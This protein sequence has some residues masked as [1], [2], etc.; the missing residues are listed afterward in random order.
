M[1][2]TIL[3]LIISLTSL[4]IMA[5]SDDERQWDSFVDYLS[6]NGARISVSR[7]NDVKRIATR[8]NIVFENKD[9]LRKGEVLN[10][11]NRVPRLVDSIRVFLDGKARNSIESYRYEN[12]SD[13]TDTIT[14]SLALKG[15]GKNNEYLLDLGKAYNDNFLWSGDY[16]MLEQTHLATYPSRHQLQEI[17][18]LLSLKE[19]NRK[20]WFRTMKTCL[21]DYVNGNGNLLILSTEENTAKSPY[22]NFHME[23]FDS[24]LAKETKTAKAYPI[25]YKYDNPK[26][27]AS[28]H[29]PVNIIKNIKNDTDNTT[30]YHS[31][32]FNRDDIG[33]SESTG[34]LY[35]ISKENAKECYR[36]LLEKAKDYVNNHPEECCEI[37]MSN[38]HFSFS[39]LRSTTKYRINHIALSDYVLAEMGKDGTLYI[40]RLNVTGDY[41]IPKN[42]KQIKSAINGR[43][44]LIKK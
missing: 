23:S 37:E 42:W 4:S 38:R 19:S 22:H 39:G 30:Y 26:D 1:K 40:L 3:T 35:I 9:I 20:M 33:A 16:E 6:E 25:K 11:N 34:M 18:M 13:M 41:W 15:Y 27:S 21:F 24:L 5:Q 32:V 14:Y 43:V 8:Y 36:T 12:H 7:M 17:K 28:K 29:Q 10:D 31:L 2:A 44:T